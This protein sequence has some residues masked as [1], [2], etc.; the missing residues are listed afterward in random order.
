M[1]KIRVLHVLEEHQFGGAVTRVTNLIRGIS[2]NQFKTTLCI[3][4][5]NH[6][7]LTTTLNIACNVVYCRMDGLWDL[8]SIIRLKKIIQE[9]GIDIVHT[10]LPRADVIGRIAARLAGVS[11][12]FTTIAALDKHRERWSR[13]PHALADRITSRFATS[14]ICVSEAVKQHFCRWHPALSDRAITIY[15][16][17]E[18]QKFNQRIDSIEAKRAFKLSIKVPVIGITA[19]L[20]AVKGI[21]YLLSAVQKLAAQKI[22]LKCLI[23][24]DGDLRMRLEAM[25]RELGIQDRV[26]FTGRCEDVRKALAAMDVF[27]LPSIAEGLPNSLLE[28][29]AMRKPVV[30]SAV[31]GILEIVSNGE[32]GVLVPVRNPGQLASAIANLLSSPEKCHKMAE[33]GYRKV[34]RYFDN[35]KAIHA[36]ESLYIQ[37]MESRLGVDEFIEAADLLA[38]GKKANC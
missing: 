4:G 31:G 14:I 6:R 16:G 8:I 21:E 35:Q 32:T 20:C 28:A 5:R 3:L 22:S 19:R 13:A 25:V 1:R 37:S 23:V 17:I 18:L 36:Y 2:S 27:V 38:S 30:A 12:I 15:H 9:C 7:S 11:V 29:M 24:G 34:T 26:I 10:H 33:N